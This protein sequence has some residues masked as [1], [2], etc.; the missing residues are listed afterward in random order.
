M[1]RTLPP[2][3][4]LFLDKTDE[5]RPLY[6]TLRCADQLVLDDIFELIQQHQFASQRARNLLPLEVLVWL[7]LLEEHKRV[8]QLQAQ[9]EE[10]ILRLRA[11]LES[12]Q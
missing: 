5:L 12:A 9:L 1:A 6:A 10:E 2:A 4:Q 3:T 8:N 11:E 7:I